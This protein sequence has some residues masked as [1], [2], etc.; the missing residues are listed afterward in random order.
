MEEILNIFGIDVRL[1][2][3]QAFNFA[4]LLLAL[5]YFLYRPVIGILEKRKVLIEEGVLDAQKAKDEKEKV[6]ADRESILVEATK[7]ASILIDR[8]KERAGEKEATLLSIS[9]EKS[10]RILNE[11]HAKAEEERKLILEKGKIEIAR[12]V[13]LGAE[14]ILREKK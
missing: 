2:I 5:W 6:L 9:E 13:V 10:K 14:K 7:D 12:M 8:A 11:A 3:I 4:V 1:L